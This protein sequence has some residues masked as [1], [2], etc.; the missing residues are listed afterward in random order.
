V[1]P[2]ANGNASPGGWHN[3][4]PPELHGVVVPLAAY[5]T[6]RAFLAGRISMGDPA[7]FDDLL[8]LDPGCAELAADCTLTARALAGEET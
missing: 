2:D 6:Q 3:V 8:A 5:F 7:A 4:L 1:R